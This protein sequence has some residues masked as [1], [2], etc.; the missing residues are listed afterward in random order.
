[1]EHFFH[2]YEEF[3]KIDKSLDK[4]GYLAIMT[5]F[6]TNDDLFADWY[7]RRDP[8]HVVF[9]KKKTFQVIASLMNWNISIPSKDIVIFHKKL[10]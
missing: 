1:M 6:M 4:N 10:M 7:Y 2:P 5:C 3:K 9:Y 8:T